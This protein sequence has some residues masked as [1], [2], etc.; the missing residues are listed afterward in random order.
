MTTTWTDPRGLERTGELLDQAVINHPK[1]G[2]FTASFYRTPEREAFN[3][4]YWTIE[5]FTAAEK[6]L[7]YRMENEEGGRKRM[8]QLR[9]QA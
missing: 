4:E 7:V 1:M 6:T 2:V 8:A 5:I 9:A 3:R